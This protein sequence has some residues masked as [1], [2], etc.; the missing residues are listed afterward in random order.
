MST[1]DA[2]VTGATGLLG[3][4]IVRRL[5]ESGARV[6]CLVRPTSST[7]RI[8]GPQVE[9]A[10][11]DLNDPAQLAALLK[12]VSVVYHF[13]GHLT[14][15]S[16]LNAHED[17]SMYRLNV[18]STTALLEAAAQSG[19]QRFVYASSVAVY[20]AD[21][22]SPISED[23]QCSPVAA[24]GRSKVTAEAAVMDYHR[25]GLA[26]TVIRPAICIG[27]WDRHFLPA[28]RRVARLPILPIVGGGRNLLDIVSALDIA[29]LAVTAASARAGAGRVYNGGSGHPGSL[30]DLITTLH[31]VEGSPR[32]LIVPVSEGMMRFSAPV[33]RRIV[34]LVAPGMEGTMSTVGAR[35]SAHD[36]YYDMSRARA[37]LGFTPRYDF[38]RGLERAR[39]EELA[40]ATA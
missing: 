11:A 9:L 23:S 10:Q 34:A 18:D 12:G 8:Q 17:D 1:V 22:V 6:R 20:S 40:A 32:P 5:V 36:V 35:Y 19:V 27:A 33:A 13:A 2:V 30:A 21:A 29:E 39:E 37:E 26:G 7:A 4:H 38:R 16:P 3:A 24:Y 25:R 28:A 15:A 31:E 14:A